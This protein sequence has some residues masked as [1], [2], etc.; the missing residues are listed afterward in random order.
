MKLTFGPCSSSPRSTL[1]KA[2]Y[3]GRRAIAAAAASLSLLLAPRAA[4]ALTQPNGTVIPQTTNLVTFLNGQGEAIDPLTQAATTP[5]TFNPQC[6]LTFTVIGRGAGQRNSFGW[7]NVTGVKPTLA[8]LHMFIGCNDGVGVSKVLDIKNDPGYAGGLIGFFEATTEGH[9]CPFFCPNCVDLNNPGGTLG[10][11]YY[12]EKVYNED[13]IPGQQSWIHLLIMNSVVIPNAFYF[14]WED[15]FQGGDNDFEDLLT[16]VEGIQCSG[17]GAPC[18]T[19]LAGKCGFGAMQCKNGALECVQSFLPTAESCNGIDDDCNDLIDDGNLCTAPEVCFKGHCEPPCGGGEFVCPSGLTCNPDGLC[20]D[21]LCTMVICP[22]G[23]VCVGGVCSSPCTG[24]TCPYHQVCIGGLCVDP[25]DS[26]TCDP[27]YYCET[28]VCVLGC[29]CS[30]CASGTV[31]DANLHCVPTGCENVTC[32]PGEHCESGGVCVSDCNGAVCPAGQICQNGDCVN[33]GGGAGATTGSG[34][35]F[36]TGAFNVGGGGVV[37]AGAGG[38]AAG[39]PTGAGGAGGNPDSPGPGQ[40]SGCG[41]PSAAAA[42][43]APPAAPAQGRSRLAG[44]GVLAIVVAGLAL[45]GMKRRRH[46]RSR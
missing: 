21:P 14:G 10:H 35:G 18:D 23:E 7:Y 17:G 25:C 6:N 32:P 30:A 22:E 19:G 3:D 37:T 45:L 9:D 31:C 38:S 36:S 1:H 2:P 43:A 11:I 46:W 33:G 29:A 42:T 27:G 34:G 16:R 5:E 40:D 41:C 12:S 26:I 24:V 15:L 8:E 4:A 28:G 39:S 20:V 44:R 13:N